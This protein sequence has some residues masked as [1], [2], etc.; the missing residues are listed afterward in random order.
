MICDR[1][2]Y[3][4]RIIVVG[5][6]K[7][8]T[9][10]NWLSICQCICLLMINMVIKTRLNLCQC[11]ECVYQEIAALDRLKTECYRY[12]RRGVRRRWNGEQWIKEWSQVF[13]KDVC[14]PALMKAFLPS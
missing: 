14:L 4:I 5:W 13:S 8:M 3:D 12:T 9:L 10:A 2:T 6:T 7:R 11:F 1:S